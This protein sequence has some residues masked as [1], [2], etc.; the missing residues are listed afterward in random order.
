MEAASPVVTCTPGGAFSSQPV[1][2]TEGRRE[3]PSLGQSWV[4]GGADAKPAQCLGMMSSTSSGP[5]KT[6][7]QNG[8]EA[9][10]SPGLTSPLPSRHLASVFCLVSL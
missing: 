4:G 1:P 3:W 5:G 9:N 10:P 7:G 8:Q 6:G 2:C